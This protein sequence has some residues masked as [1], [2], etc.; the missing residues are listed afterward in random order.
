MNHAR[1]LAAVALLLSACSNYDFAAA[2]L[3]SGAWDFPKLIADL[4]HS[5]ETRLS[6]GLWLPLIHL[7]QTTFRAAD[8]GTG[9]TMKATSCSGPL[10]CI[11][12]MDEW[13]V[14]GGGTTYERR[15]RDWVLWGLPWFADSEFVET[16]RGTRVRTD[17]RILLLIDN[18]AKAY[19]RPKP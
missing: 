4:E 10:F 15:E 11:G 13:F 2:R 17:S 16:Q 18:G 6:D 19:V 3:P 12:E 14:D 5:G 1:T 7:E 8:G 9:Y